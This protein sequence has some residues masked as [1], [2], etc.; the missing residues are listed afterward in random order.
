MSICY[1]LS[2]PS[3]LNKDLGINLKMASPELETYDTTLQEDKPMPILPSNK[4]TV[5]EDMLRFMPVQ[6]VLSGGEELA[7]EEI[8]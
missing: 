2:E 7:K 3:D 6:R 4:L 1:R 5:E 8:G